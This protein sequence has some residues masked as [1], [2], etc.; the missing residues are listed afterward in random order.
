MKL[1]PGQVLCPCIAWDR[2]PAIHTGELSERFKC[3]VNFKAL[4]K[5]ITKIRMHEVIDSQVQAQFW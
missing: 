1:A 5:G 3:K 4:V 2:G